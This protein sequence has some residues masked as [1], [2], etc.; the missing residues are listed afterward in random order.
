MNTQPT[1]MVTNVQKDL[2]SLN[3]KVLMHTGIETD[4]GTFYFLLPKYHQSFLWEGSCNV[5]VEQPQEME[6]EIHKEG[7]ASWIF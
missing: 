7:L 6:R 2:K 5:D 1:S 4:R 3:H